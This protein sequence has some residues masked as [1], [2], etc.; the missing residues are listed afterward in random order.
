MVAV[1]LRSLAMD[2]VAWLFVVL[3]LGAAVVAACQLIRVVVSDVIDRSASADAAIAPHVRHGAGEIGRGSGLAVAWITWLLLA[4]PLMLP[5]SDVGV[6]STAAW[7][8]A[9]V[10]FGSVAGILLG[11]VRLTPMVSRYFP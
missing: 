5:V 7:L 10:L 11:H 8:L 6:I 4:P 3:A 9:G 1:S 2:A